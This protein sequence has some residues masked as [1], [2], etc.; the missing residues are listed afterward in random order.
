MSDKFYKWWK[1]HR[2]VITFGGFLTL[3]GLF[4]S[5]VIKEANYKNTCIKISTKGAFN[6]FNV[7]NIEETL[8]KETGLNIKELAKIEGYKN[9]IK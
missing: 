1:N 2:R 7:D 6:K 4:V 9:C 5:P 3:L 8:L